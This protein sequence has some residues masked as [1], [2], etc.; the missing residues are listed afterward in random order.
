MTAQQMSGWWAGYVYPWLAER[1]TN[2]VA[3]SCH[4]IDKD[5]SQL[6]TAEDAAAA[7]HN[8]I[9]SHVLQQCPFGCSRSFGFSR[10]DPFAPHPCLGK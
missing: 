8:P 1:E 4:V 7:K 9:P 10:S 3:Q 6:L 2:H 5:R